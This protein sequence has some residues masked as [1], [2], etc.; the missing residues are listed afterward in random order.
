MEKVM[1]TVRRF[2]SVA[3]LVG[4]MSMALAACGDNNP[5]TPTAP[6]NLPPTVTPGGPAGGL[7]EYQ[8]T[9]KEWAIEPKEMTVNAGKARFVVANAGTFD[10]DL[11]IQGQ[12]GTPIFKPGTGPQNLDVQLSAGTYKWLCD[13]PG[14]EQNG[15]V[16]TL[17]VK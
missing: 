7:T 2:W 5:P 13:I 3:A 4:L 16:G 11:V 9:L 15:M 10:H 6:P 8:V 14:H 12:G 17:T 1:A